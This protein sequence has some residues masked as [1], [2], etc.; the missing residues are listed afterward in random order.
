[1]DNSSIYCQGMR[2]DP[3]TGDRANL[4]RI[5]LNLQNLRRIELNIAPL[6]ATTILHQELL[7]K[8]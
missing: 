2:A 8:S 6:P 5:Y 3:E 1:M 7:N 4:R